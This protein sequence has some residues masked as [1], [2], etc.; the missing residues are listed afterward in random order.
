MNTIVDW[1]HSATLISS[2]WHSVLVLLSQY[3]VNT[4]MTT[5]VCYWLIILATTADGIRHNI[6]ALTPAS[7][8]WLL[9]TTRMVIGYRTNVEERDSQSAYATRMNNIVIILAWLF[10]RMSADTRDGN[11]IY[12]A[13]PSRAIISTSPRCCLQHT[14][15]RYVA[16]GL[17][18]CIVTGVRA[19][20]ALL[21]HVTVAVSP[22]VIHILYHYIVA[23]IGGRH[24]L[25]VTHLRWRYC[26]RLAVV[27]LYRYGDAATS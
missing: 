4:A 5:L 3:H 13:M 2:H 23:A 21:I 15:R 16:V 1:S 24:W 10:W 14:A 19:L 11:S 22:L 8:S 7:L 27:T 9:V 25:R 17:E 12:A 18:S 26:R 20:S 6:H